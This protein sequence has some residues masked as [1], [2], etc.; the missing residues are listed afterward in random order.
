MRKKHINE[1]SFLRSIAC[2]SIVLLHSIAWGM[3]Y[4]G[5]LLNLPE[6]SEVILDSINVFLYYGTPTFIFITAFILGY[7]YK[8]KTSIPNGFLTKRL[9]FILIPYVFMAFL[10]ASPYAL[11]SLEQYTMKVL[12]NIFIGDFHAYFVLIIFQFYLLFVLCKKW[13]DRAHPSKVIIYSLF[14]NVAYLCI[15]NFTNPINFI[16]SDYVWERFYWIPFPGWIFYF[17]IAYYVGQNYEAFIRYIQKYKAIVIAAPFVTGIVLLY[18]YHSGLLTIHSS[19]RIDILFHT[20]SV[21]AFIIY[22]AMK[23]KAIPSFFMMVNKYSYGI[24]LLHTS[25]ISIFIVFFTILSVN[26]G[27]FTILILFVAS[28]TFSILTIYYLNRFAIGKYI[29]GKVDLPKRVKKVGSEAVFASNNHHTN[30]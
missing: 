25:Y 1:I 6:Y 22:F 17:S 30:S 14:I 13:L 26:F 18:F 7:S 12:L 28:T 3:E 8:E 23:M 9:K 15:F 19:K 27:I 29:V 16:F 24:Y 10:Y 2:L 4:V 21:I 11:V 20:L 5:F